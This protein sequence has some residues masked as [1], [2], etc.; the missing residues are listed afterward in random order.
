MINFAPKP[1]TVSASDPTTSNVMKQVTQ[2]S[3]FGMMPSININGSLERQALP[4]LR[5]QT[6]GKREIVCMK[7]SDLLDWMKEKHVDPEEELLLYFKDL[8][9]VGFF[10]S[11]GLTGWPH[12]QLIAFAVVVGLLALLKPLLYFPLFTRFHASPRTALLAANSLANHSEFGLIEI[13]LA[14]GVGWLDPKWSSAMSIALAVSFVAASPLNRASHG[15]YDRW[16][17]RLLRYESRRV[18]A[19]LPDTREARILVLGMG[20][21]GTGAYEAM[22]REHGGEVLGIDENDRKLAEHRAEHRRVA[23][24]DASDPDFWHR[25]ALDRVEL[26]M[27]ALT[28]HQENLLVARLLH[29]MGY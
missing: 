21:V 25:V 16:R 28:N 29:R 5:Y 7:V 3:M 2:V 18:R 1:I 22:A 15:L 9:L 13:A 26:I 23:A 4:S 17:S 24:A 11:I 8:F 6:K 20:R 27:L 14:A 10:L 12:P 19:G